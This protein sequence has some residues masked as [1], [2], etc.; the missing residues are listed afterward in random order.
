[1]S[2]TAPRLSRFFHCALLGALCLGAAAARA[3]TFLVTNAGTGNTTEYDATGAFLGV[4]ANEDQSTG[5]LAFFSSGN[6]LISNAM[7]STIS[8]YNGT[9]GTLVGNFAS[10]GLNFPAGQ[11]FSSSGNLFV[12]NNSN[13]TVAQYNGTTG[14]FV[15]IFANTGMNDPEGLAISTSG[16]LFVTNIVNNTVAQ[17]NG[18]TGAFVGNFASTGLNTPYGLAFSSSGNLFVVNIGNNTVAQYNGTTGDLVGTFAS[19]GLSQPTGLAFSSSGNLFVLNGFD[20]TIS[21]YNGTTGAFVGTFASMGMNEPRF[22]VAV[23]APGF[24]SQPGN[25][26]VTPGGQTAFTVTA[27][28]HPFLQW[29]RKPHGGSFGNLTNDSTYAGVTTAVLMVTGATLGMS[30]DQFR[31]VATNVDSSVSSA[32]VTLTVLIPVSITKQPASLS[33]KANA[34]VKF[35]VTA[36][37]TGPLKYQWKRN[38][39]ALKN[40]THITGATT[41]AVSLKKITT[42]DAGSYT[43]LVTG[44]AGSHAT[45]KTAK[46]TVKK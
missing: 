27:S 20:N 46:L 18:T 7:N 38:N 13:N 16:N 35:S 14:A 34:T 25:Q 6:L 3:D 32:T 33:A 26:T 8:E 31:C 24:P 10:T 39:V 4:F 23:P 17:Y 41:A 15:G 21:Q 11:A 43:V 5:G 12:V 42:K 22:I 1:M 44:A 2:V 30:G 40:S 45:S 37:G 36:A 29:Q 28:G 19:T 9:T